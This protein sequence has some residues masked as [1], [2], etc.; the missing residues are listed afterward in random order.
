[1]IRSV[2]E[3][4]EERVAEIGEGGRTK[5][6]VSTGRL[7]GFKACLANVKRAPKAGLVINREA[8]ELLEVDVGST[9]LAVPR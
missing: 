9:I 3:S 6:L 5:M 7:N 1:M 2:R 4:A 8:A